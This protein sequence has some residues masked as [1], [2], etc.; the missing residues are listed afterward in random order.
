MK[1]EL[2]EAM[3]KRHSIRE[4]EPKKV[5]REIINK[6]VLN[7]SKA[8]SAGNWQPWKFYIVD[9]E[10]KIKQI[11]KLHGSLLIKQKK[12]INKLEKRVKTVALNFYETLGNCKTVILIYI[13]KE[14][15]E[16]Y[17][18]SKILSVSAA[19]ENLM[20]SALKYDL[21][22]CWMGS[23]KKIEKEINKLLKIKDKELITGILIGCPKKGYTP[24][25]RKK[26]KLNE[27]LKFI[28]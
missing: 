13:D 5:S 12:E 28:K 15:N 14:K 10:K 4:F 8:P 25:K 2:Q 21:G 18:L 26:K 17:R 11:S 27:I 7:A 16:E 20:L 24:L 1:M 3:D 9:S 19:I 23:F 6:L 22:T